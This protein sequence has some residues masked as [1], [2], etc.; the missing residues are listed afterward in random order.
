M[1]ATAAD[2]Y[3]KCLAG[4]DRDLPADAAALPTAA[5]RGTA[6]VRANRGDQQ[7]GDAVRHDVGCLASAALQTLRRARGPGVGNGHR[8]VRGGACHGLAHAGGDGRIRV[9]EA[10]APAAAPAAAE[11]AAIAAA[12]PLGIAAAAPA[13]AAATSRTETAVAPRRVRGGPQ[14]AAAAGPE[15]NTG[16]AA[17]AGGPAVAAAAALAR[18]EHA[19]VST[20]AAPARGDQQHVAAKRAAT[21]AGVA[22]GSHLRLVGH[23]AEVNDPGR[24]AAAHAGHGRAAVLAAVAAPGVTVAALAAVLGGGK[25]ADAPAPHVDLQ[26]MAGNDRQGGSDDGAFTRTARTALGAAGS[27]L[28]MDGDPGDAGRHVEVLRDP[29]AAERHA[30]RTVGGYSRLHTAQPREHQRQQAGPHNNH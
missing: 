21:T 7:P 16:P 19:A 29:Q 27:A 30:L 6:A 12:T 23:V 28:R 18:Y 9:V 17:A 13:A 11:P 25:A 10:A 5:A 26:R 22:W 1:L 4:R 14:A 3:E 24:P 2:V 8:A 15:T 20:A